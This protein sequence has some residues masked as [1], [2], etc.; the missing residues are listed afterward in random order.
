[1]AP[2][3]GAEGVYIGSLRTTTGT[4]SSEPPDPAGVAMAPVGTLV[5]NF[6]SSSDASMSFWVDGEAGARSLTRHVFGP[7]P[8]C[9]W[10]PD[11]DLAAATNYQDLWWRAPAG[12]DE[13]WKVS[14][15]HQGDLIVA[16][17]NAYDTNGESWWLAGQLQR[18]QG[19]G[20]VFSGPVSTYRGPPFNA[21]YAQGDVVQTVVGSATVSFSDGNTGTFAYSVDGIS[22]AKPITRQIFGPSG[23]TICR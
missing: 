16:N 13:G 12:S 10:Q 3:L 9:F 1:M 19:G 7:V 21:P 6:G 23:G 20:N 11:A 22:E 2:W 4:G 17:W 8:T 15:T 18:Q 14:V 5:V